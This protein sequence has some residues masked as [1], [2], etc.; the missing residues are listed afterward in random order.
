MLILCALEQER[1]YH[2]SRIELD[3]SLI[4]RI[5]AGDGVAFEMLYHAT[6]SAVFGYALS[7]VKNRQDAEDVMHD[8]YLNIQSY[9]GRYVPQ[10][11]PMAWILTIVKH[12]A[13][14]QCNHPS[15]NHED[16]EH[17]WEVF[18]QQ[19]DIEHAENRMLLTALLA[20]LPDQEREIVVLHAQ[21]GM[22]HREIAAILDL[23]LATVLSKYHRALGKLQKATQF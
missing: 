22:K 14:A 11:K 16:L 1:S 10:G 23:P 8:C 15:R 4:A 17:Q 7:I 12:L 18:H 2:K 9:A 21:T 3:E 13:F 6:D 20:Q 5:G 19:N